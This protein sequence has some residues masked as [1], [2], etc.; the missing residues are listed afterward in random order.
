[1]G[2]GDKIKA[3][4]TH[5]PPELG[6]C[7]IFFITES[8]CFFKTC[9]LLLR[10]SYLKS[11]IN[12]QSNWLDKKLGKKIIFSSLNKL[13]TTAS[14]DLC[15]HLC[16][17]SSQRL[18]CVVPWTCLSGKNLPNLPNCQTAKLSNSFSGSVFNFI[19]GFC[20]DETSTRAKCG[21]CSCN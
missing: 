20:Q 17:R 14:A 7:G 9:N 18:L 4:L 15:S 19:L 13:K 1:M 5:S 3:S 2:F 21:R 6:T 16:G 10:K 12:P 11:L 8:T